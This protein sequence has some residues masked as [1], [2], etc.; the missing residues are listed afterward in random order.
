MNV[1]AGAQ[2]ARSPT[3]RRAARSPRRPTYT[4]TLKP[5]LKF[6]NG[7]PLTAEDVAF[8]FNRII[9]INDPNGPAS[10]IAQHG[11]GGRPRTPTTVVFTLK[12][13]NDQ[14]WPFVLGTSA[15][16]IVDSK[17]FPADKLLTDEKVVGSGPVRDQLA[18]S[19]NQLVELKAN[20]NYTGPQQGRRRTHDHAEVLHRVRRT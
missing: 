19:K 17:V 14:T 4:C 20:P 9:K 10:L 18:T 3:P 7:D 2:G 16:P 11:L 5:G 13:A 6:S 1:P 8:S 12:N 15:G